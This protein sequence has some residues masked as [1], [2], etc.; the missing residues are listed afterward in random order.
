M[1]C[2]S[3]L[4]PFDKAE[5]GAAGSGQYA[6]PKCKQEFCMDC[7]IFVHEVLH[8]CPGCWSI[9]SKAHDKSHA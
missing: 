9:A 6:C 1:H 8:N 3:C 5:A 2:F 7:D 4:V